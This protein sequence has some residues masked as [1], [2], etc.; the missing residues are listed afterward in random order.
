M[1]RPFKNPLKD[2][3][4]QGKVII[5]TGV[6]RNDTLVTEYLA[7]IGYEWLLIDAEHGNLDFETVQLLLQSMNGT[8]CVP[9]VRP[10]WNDFNFIKRMLDMGAYGIMIPLVSTKEETELAVKACKYPPE[11]FRGYCPRR[12]GLF[13]WKEYYDVANKEVMVVIQLETVEGLEKVDEIMSVPGLDACCVG[14][15]DLTSSLGLGIPPSFDSFLNDPRY[16]A[17]SEAFDRVLKSAQQHGV[18]PSIFVRGEN[19]EWAIEKGFKLIC[20]DD[21]DFFLFRGAQEALAKAR[22]AVEKFTK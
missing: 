16:S 10:H 22:Q 9:I 1:E 13:D 12:A 7:G 18:T 21:A 19:V 4:K 17:V 5:G 3:L 2:K 6:A 14:P 15:W 11:G 8:G 20:V